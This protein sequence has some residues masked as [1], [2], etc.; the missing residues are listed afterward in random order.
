MLVEGEEETGSPSLSR[1]LDACQG[2]LHA[3]MVV[4]ADARTGP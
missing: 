4:F 2:R 3:D 1:F